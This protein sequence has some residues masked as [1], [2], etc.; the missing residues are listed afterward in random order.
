MVGLCLYGKKKDAA[1][2]KIV[3][4]RGEEVAHI[5]RFFKIWFDL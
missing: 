5:Y 1:R 4:S 3:L 2:Y